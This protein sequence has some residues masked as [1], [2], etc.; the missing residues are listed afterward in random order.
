MLS[1]DSLLTAAQSGCIPKLV[2]AKRDLVHDGEPPDGRQC[3]CCI[4]IIISL[5]ARV[6]K[7]PLPRQDRGRVPVNRCL[8]TL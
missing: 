7:A 3:V 4:G 8:C 1:G 6:A 5:D 2:E